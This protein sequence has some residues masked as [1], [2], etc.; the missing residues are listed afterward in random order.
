[1]ARVDLKADRRAGTLLVPGAW[2][3]AGHEPGD[4]AGRLA[5]ALSDRAAWLGLEHIGRPER[6]DLAAPLAAALRPVLV[7]PRTAS[8]SPADEPAGATVDA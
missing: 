8:R 1:V 5:G 4:V 2:A 7:R 3:E 6:G